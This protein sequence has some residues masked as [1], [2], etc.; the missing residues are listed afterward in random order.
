M[1]DAISSLV[2]LGK[3]ASPH[4]GDNDHVAEEGELCMSNNSPGKKQRHS[5][6]ELVL[7]QQESPVV[8]EDKVTSPMA[9]YRDEANR[10]MA[11][12]P[13]LDMIVCDATTERVSPVQP[14]PSE[15]EVKVTDKIYVVAE[16]PK[17][18]EIDVVLEAPKPLDNPECDLVQPVSIPSPDKDILESP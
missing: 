2:Q 12:T 1:R 7:E 10:A 5:D 6:V 3:R 15:E 8:I 17:P 11:T 16:A 18:S 9:E 13:N 4:K 14:N